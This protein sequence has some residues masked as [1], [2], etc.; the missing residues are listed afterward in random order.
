MARRTR[1][2]HRSLQEPS[3]EGSHWEEVRHNLEE[4]SIEG[5][6][7]ERRKPAEEDIGVDNRLGVVLHR[8]SEADKDTLLFGVAPDLGD[9]HWGGTDKTWRWGRAAHREWRRD[10]CCSLME[11]SFAIGYR[12]P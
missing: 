5:S 1:V 6:H 11:T 12:L 10:F 7:W 8:D 9:N 4:P 3:I 2:V